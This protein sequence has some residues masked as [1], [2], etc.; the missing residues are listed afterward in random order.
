MYKPPPIP[1]DDEIVDTIYRVVLDLFP[2]TCPNCGKRYPDLASYIR[3]TRKIGPA[4]SL[5]AEMDSWRPS[6][7]VGGIAM[8][9]CACGTTLALTTEHMS[10]E[11]SHR[12]LNWVKANMNKRGM[13]SEQLTGLI[14]EKIRERALKEAET[15]ASS[16]SRTPRD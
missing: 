6:V 16:S 13:S 3:G 11:D 9:N 10:V 7:P 15:T 8:A 2:K 14:R 5:D 12:V 4:Y 1:T